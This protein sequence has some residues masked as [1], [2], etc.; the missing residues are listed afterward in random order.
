MQA[1]NTNEMAR[2]VADRRKQDIQPGR[3]R[4]REASKAGLGT[5]LGLWNEEERM[6]EEISRQIVMQVQWNKSYV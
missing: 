3:R 4:P 1:K 2:W 5:V 6:A